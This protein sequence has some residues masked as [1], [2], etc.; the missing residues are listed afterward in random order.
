M[1]SVAR[2]P[3]KITPKYVCVYKGSNLRSPRRQDSRQPPSLTS[4][5]RYITDAGGFRNNLRPDGELGY[6]FPLFRSDV[7]YPWLYVWYKE[8]RTM[9]S[10]FRFMLCL[11][12]E[13]SISDNK[14][15]IIIKYLNKIIS[16]KDDNNSVLIL[17]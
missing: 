12:F 10:K 6:N 2:R 3:W 14:K 15:I 5:F 13:H 7:D 17:H 9:K 8:E 16:I 1:E 11:N 4:F